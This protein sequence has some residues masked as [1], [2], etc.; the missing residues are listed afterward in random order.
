[1]VNGE[2]IVDGRA[3][4]P[5][6]KMIAEWLVEVYNNIPEEIGWNAWKKRDYEWMYKNARIVFVC[7]IRGYI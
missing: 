4:E 5:S 2:G 7:L 6:R 3:K 1:M